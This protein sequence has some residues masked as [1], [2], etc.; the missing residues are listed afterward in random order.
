MSRS[1]HER[2]HKSQGPSEC[3]GQAQSSAPAA[4]RRTRR[5]LR[6]VVFSLAL[7]ALTLLGWR[8]LEARSSGI[9]AGANILL[10]TLDTTRADRLGCYGH[11]A[12]ST[13]AL[14]QLAAG[15]TCF[16]SA[17]AQIPLTLPSHASLLTGMHPAEL[18]IL[19]NG[20]AALPDDV[21]TL[22][23]TCR[24]RGYRTAAFLAASVL[25]GRF[26]L[27]AGFDVYDDE[28]PAPPGGVI[29]FDQERPANV[30]CDR[31]L[32]WLAGNTDSPFFCWVHFFD[33]HGPYEPPE[34]FRSRLADPYDGEVAFADTQ[35]GRLMSW[36]QAHE[37][38]DRTLVVVASDHG[39]GLG[40]HGESA[41]GVFLYDST[42][43]VPLILSMPTRI[44]AG[45]RV[46]AVVSLVDILPTLLELLG[47]PVPGA[48]SGTSFA[49]A[50]HGNRLPPQSSY[51]R[52]DY[53]LDHFGWGRLES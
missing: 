21:E 14:D 5:V 49:G 11:A 30:V 28:L 9:A 8:L 51:A 10:I 6:A 43:R 47:W 3:T 15:G 50:L 35:V 29:E 4:P 39:E 12:A 36:L 33:P 27:S 20:R 48:V 26:G 23:E 38:A 19:D 17:F 24:D 16:D 45:R 18:G 31:A 42:I 41:H 13:P 25:D 37:L 40:E 1:Q 44:A 53:A 2:R 32:A 34:P 7:L 22:A 52:S 46:T